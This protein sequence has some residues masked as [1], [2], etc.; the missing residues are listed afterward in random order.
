MQIF[1]L[2]VSN[3]LKYIIMYTFEA[4]AAQKV[5]LEERLWLVPKGS[6]EAVGWLGI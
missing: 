3:W 1:K 6:A 4:K 2:F 5:S